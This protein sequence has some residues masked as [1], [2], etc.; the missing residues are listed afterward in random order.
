MTPTGL[1][2]HGEGNPKLGSGTWAKE[3]CGVEK[4][5]PWGRCQCQPPAPTFPRAGEA[6][7]PSRGDAVVGL[8][9]RRGPALLTC[10]CRVWRASQ[11]TGACG[12]SSG[13]RSRQGGMVSFLYLSWQN[14]MAEAQET[15]VPLGACS[16]WRG[17][18]ASVVALSN[19]S[20]SQ[21]AWL[22]SASA[23]LVPVPTLG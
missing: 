15:S 4:T 20:L 1:S 12:G 9:Q 6:G 3:L 18:P 10:V 21:A 11:G 14:L 22:D 2:P 17:N 13:G 7:G 19:V 8:L 16:C 23:S 5:G